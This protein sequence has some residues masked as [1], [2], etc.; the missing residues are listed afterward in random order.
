MILKYTENYATKCFRIKKKE[1]ALKFNFEQ[2]RANQP[3]SN[4]ALIGKLRMTRMTKV[5]RQTDI[6]GVTRVTRVT[7]M[8]R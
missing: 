5:M 1:P 3:L 8:M 4:W 2:L 6:T 7:R